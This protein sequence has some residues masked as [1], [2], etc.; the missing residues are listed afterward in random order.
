[1]GNQIIRQPN[2]LLAVFS[3]ET[4]TITVYDA[5]EAELVEHF[6]EEAAERARE[7]VRRTLGH[8]AAGNPRKAYFQFA[9]TWEEALEEDREHGGSVWQ[10]FVEVADSE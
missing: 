1:M 5:T 2:G 4:D 3:T 8:V 6:A 7:N 10:S 9:M